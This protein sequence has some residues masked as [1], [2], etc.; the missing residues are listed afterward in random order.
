LDG[1]VI[2]MCNEGYQSSLA[3]VTLQEL[4]FGRATDMAGGFQAWRA[5]GLPVGPPAAAPVDAPAMAPVDAPATA[6][7][8]SPAARRPAN[9]PSVPARTQAPQIPRSGGRHAQSPYR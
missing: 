5:A 1:H 8:N 2:L 7:V 9:P 6:L 4:G 3:A